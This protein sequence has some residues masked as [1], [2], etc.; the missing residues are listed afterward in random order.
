MVLDILEIQKFLPHRYPFLL[1]D[2]VLEIEP[3]KRATA[4]KNVSI[5]EPYFQGHFPHHPIM[6][7]VLMI[8]AMAQLG[9]IL[10]MQ[11]SC[12]QGKTALLAGV[13]KC[14]FKQQVHPGDQLIIH[15]ELIKLRQSIGKIEAQIKIDEQLVTQASLLFGLVDEKS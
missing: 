5:N 11:M 2:R 1:L 15:V 12:A 13:D 14:R 6:P 10:L 7:G 3:E 4:L 8:E 9:G